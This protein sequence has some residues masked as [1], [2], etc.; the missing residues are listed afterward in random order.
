MTA[1]TLMKEILNKA[2]ALV[3]DFDGTLVDSNPIK[4]K[5]FDVC[6][7]ELK[8]EWPAIKAYCYTHHHTPRWEKFKH[9]YVNI[10]KKSYTDDIAKD[11]HERYAHATTEAVV[12]APET[13]GA[14]E[15]LKSIQG[16]YITALLSSTP[17][18]VLM[19]ILDK[20]KWTAFFRTIQGAPVNK[21]SWLKKF[22]SDHQ[23]KEG[24]T[25]FFGD[26]AEDAASA[27]KAACLFVA[28]AN[29]K[30]AGSSQFFIPDFLQ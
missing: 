26:S 30:L 23:L 22:A 21:A 1:N 3:F 9:V 10:L 28:V 6:F 2:R 12:N 20:K 8:D 18:D 7:S 15:F 5:A 27:R 25:V 14:V 19:E 4:L 16:E 17:Q 11:L 13:P 24:E 29:E